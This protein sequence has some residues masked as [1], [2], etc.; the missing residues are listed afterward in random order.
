M[1]ESIAPR[2]LAPGELGRALGGRTWLAVGDGAVRYRA[3]L[4][5]L[6]VAVP[7]DASPLHQVDARAI[8]ELGARATPDRA[9]EGGTL[10]AVLPDYL[11]RPDAEI[12]LTAR[13]SQLE[14]TGS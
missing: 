3:D 2:A 5:A 9:R 7:A 14:S 12:A 13:E 4:R 1:S 8:C 6:G 10:E 11:R